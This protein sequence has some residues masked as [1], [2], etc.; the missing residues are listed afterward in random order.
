M[1]ASGSI[2]GGEF[3]LQGE[4]PLA[5][6]RVDTPGR[7]EFSLERLDFGHLIDEDLGELPKPA[8]VVSTHGAIDVTALCSRWA[9]WIGRGLRSH[10]Q[11]GR[12]RSQESA[13]CAM[14]VGE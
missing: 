4:L 14:A 10:F 11:G 7:L 8:L 1:T 13:V 12:R 5:L 2:L 9:A 6:E 3:T